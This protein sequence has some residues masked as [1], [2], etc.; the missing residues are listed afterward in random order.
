VGA[1]LVNTLPDLDDDRAT[2][3][4]GLPHRIGA[5]ASRRLA[6]GVLLAATLLLAW[7]APSLATVGR[8]LVV[9][10][11]VV[12]AAVALR[13]AGRTPFRAVVALALVDVAVLVVAR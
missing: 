11:A 1:H 5:T 7:Q 13:G 10:A 9:A 2:G 4:N 12:L 6:V 8:V 3:V